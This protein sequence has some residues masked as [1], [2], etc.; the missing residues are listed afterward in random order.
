MKFFVQASLMAILAISSAAVPI[1]AMPVAAAAAAMPAVAAA[2]TPRWYR[3]TVFYSMEY[4]PGTLPF[5]G[6]GPTPGGTETRTMVGW[7]RYYC[8]GTVREYGIETGDYEDYYFG[9]CT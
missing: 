4:G 7:H 1:A 9:D 2:A 5:P 6:P 8:D 3:E